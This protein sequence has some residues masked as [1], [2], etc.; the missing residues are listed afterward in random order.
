MSTETVAPATA[1]AE[2][3]KASFFR[4]G[5][6]MMIT[7]V[8]GGA[9][10]FLVQVISKKLLVDEEYSAFA[11]LIQV[12][13]WM[14]IPALGLQMVFTQQSAGATSEKQRHQLVGTLKS[15]LTGTFCIW[16][17]MAVLVFLF[18]ASVI[19][20]L[21]LNNPLSLWFT[22]AVGLIMLWKPIAQGLLQGRQNFLWFG[23]LQIF[24]GVGRLTIGA[25]FVML[26][27]WQAA[28]LMAGV[29]IGMTISLSAGAW[30]NIDLLKEKSEPFDAAGWIKRVLP[31][32][33]GFG[34]ST[35]I[36]SADAIVAQNFLGADGKAADY[37]FGGTLCRAIVLFTAPLA[38][39]MFPKLVHRKASSQKGGGNLMALTLLGTGALS[40]IGVAGLWVVSPMLFKIFAKGHDTSF[41]A[42]IPLFAGGMV[43]LGM[44]NVLL[45]NLMAHSRFKIVPVL[46]LLGAGYWIALQHFHESFKQVIQVFGLFTLIYLGIC[47]LFNFVLDK[48]QDTDHPVE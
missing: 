12:T 24:D 4:Q 6:W 34:V 14:T 21:K 25:L 26:L 17:F 20:S 5:G 40:G 9:L 30:Q 2:A 42:L 29:L 41:A 13:N 8:A 33:L 10:M 44:G 45:N 18:R 35:F 38:A 37:L 3:H 15:V 43:P 19:D 22:V 28:G 11:T 7:A 31:L 32:T 46:V 36:F 48:E 27:H 1:K 16:A 39:V 47:V 23:W